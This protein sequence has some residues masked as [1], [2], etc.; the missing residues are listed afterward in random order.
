[1]ELYL[2]I[3]GIDR[4]LVWPLLL[5]AS[6]ETLPVISDKR[7]LEY[8]L[9]ILDQISHVLP[10]LLHTLAQRRNCTEVGLIIQ[11]LATLP[12]INNHSATLPPTY[13]STLFIFVC[14]PLTRTKIYIPPECALGQCLER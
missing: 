12:D 7:W 10:Q 2:A 14:F 8:A 13:I 9:V 1:M 5:S 11:M 3:K 6:I 4:A